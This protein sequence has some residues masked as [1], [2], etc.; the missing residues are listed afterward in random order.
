MQNRYSFKLEDNVNKLIIGNLNINSISSKFDELRILAE[1]KVDIL[2]A[3]E[4]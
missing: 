4:T 1:G 3:A 2:I